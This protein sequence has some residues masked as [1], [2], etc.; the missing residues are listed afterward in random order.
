VNA[1]EKVAKAIIENYDNPLQGSTI[2]VPA[3]VESLL[4][5]LGATSS[6][7][8]GKV[9][10]YG[11]DPITPDRLPYGSI[12]AIPL[13]AKAILIAKIWKERTGEGQDIHIDVRKSL[14]RLTPFLDGKWELVNGFPGRTDP[15]SPFAGG[16]DIVPTKDGKWVMFAEPY[17]ALRQ[18]ALEL[19]K[20]TGGTYQALAD[21]VKGWKGEELE[22]AAEKAGI[23][24]PLARTSKTC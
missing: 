5:S 11:A 15:Y 1:A 8:G 4:Q 24:M 3:H 20:P 16:P 23:P 14:R 19:L 7:S 2:D 13:A 18:R 12:S 9:T 17:P 22:A 21:A 6:D 10:Y